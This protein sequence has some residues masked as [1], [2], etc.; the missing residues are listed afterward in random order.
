M[1]GTVQVG[2]T[3]LCVWC[4]KY[5]GNLTPCYPP[6]QQFYITNHDAEILATLQRIEALLLQLVPQPPATTEAA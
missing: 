2:D 1:S 4:N 6:Q 5:H 3:I